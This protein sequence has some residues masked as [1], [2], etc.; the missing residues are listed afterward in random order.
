MDRKIMEVD[1]S[2]H[3]PMVLP[4]ALP[5]GLN[6]LDSRHCWCDPL[7]EIGEVGEVTVLHRH[8]TWN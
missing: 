1:Y 3:V 8:V 2:R 7:I 4:V 6:H 5:V